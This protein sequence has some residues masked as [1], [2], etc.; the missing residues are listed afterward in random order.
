MGIK[1]NK[2]LE[3]K[4]LREVSTML[5]LKKEDAFYRWS[6]VAQLIALPDVPEAHDDGYYSDE[7]GNHLNK[8]VRA[9]IVRHGVLDDMIQCA[10]LDVRL[11]EGFDSVTLETSREDG[12]TPVYTFEFTSKWVLGWLRGTVTSVKEIV[13]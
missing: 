5:R 10:E 11:H 2:Q 9:S 8:L 7:V 12:M 3:G 6:S 13:A 4:W 1:L